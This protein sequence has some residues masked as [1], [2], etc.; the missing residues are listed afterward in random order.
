MD[1]QV[2]LDKESDS[3]PAS[4]NETAQEDYI[5]T[6]NGKV[7]EDVDEEGEEADEDHHVR[8]AVANHTVLAHVLIIYA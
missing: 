8:V 1:A 6:G 2:A 5:K 7:D 3:V 4:M